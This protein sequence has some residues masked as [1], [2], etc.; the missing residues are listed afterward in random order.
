[1][2]RGDYCYHVI[3]KESKTELVYRRMEPVLGSYHD[4]LK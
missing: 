2:K 1:M 3:D 4:T